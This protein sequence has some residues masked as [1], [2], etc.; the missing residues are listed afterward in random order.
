MPK[1]VLGY[2]IG[3]PKQ[4]TYYADMLRYYRAL[5]AA[6]PRV[7]IESIGKTDEGREMIVVYISDEAS[8][9][10]LATHVEGYKKIA[11][12]RKLSD[13]DIRSFGQWWRR[14]VRSGHAGAFVR[15][16]GGEAASRERAVAIVRRAV[17]AL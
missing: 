3:K 10:N 7:S 16:Q 1:D 2:H 13:A 12:P 5:D 9:A 6:S 14:A 15:W 17:S 4:L 8:I 11:D